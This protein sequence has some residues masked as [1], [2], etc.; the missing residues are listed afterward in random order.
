M[1]QCH[2]NRDVW[3]SPTCVVMSPVFPCSG[4]LQC[5]P[6]SRSGGTVSAPARCDSAKCYNE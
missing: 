5:R 1:Q 4:F 6:G 3:M 2:V